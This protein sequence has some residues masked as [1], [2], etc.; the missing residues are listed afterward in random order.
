MRKSA[1]AG[2]DRRR[3]IGLLATSV[4]FLACGSRGSDA[5]RAPAAVS[6]GSPAQAPVDD[7]RTQL[8]GRA[9]PDG[10]LALTY[11]DGP[12][13][14]TLDLAEYLSRK[15]IAATFFVVGAWVPGLS[16]DPGKGEGV[17]ASGADFIPVLDDLRELGQRIANHTENHVLLWRVPDATVR[18]QLEA[19]QKRIDPY[20]DDELALFR[21]PGGAWNDA[22]ANAIATDAALSNL[23]GPVRWDVDRKD[24]E[25][26]L[27]CDGARSECEPAAP[28][29]AMRVKPAV[30]ARRYLDSIESAKHGIVLFHTRLGHVGSRYSVD[31]AEAIVPELEARGYVFAAPVLRFSSPDVRFPSAPEDMQSFDTE[32][33]R[34]I[35]LGDFDGDGRADVCAADGDGVVCARSMRDASAGHLPT[36]R[37]SGAFHVDIAASGGLWLA[38]IDGD[39][40]AD[41]CAR[42]HFRTTCAIATGTRFGKPSPRAFDVDGGAAIL[43]GDIDGDKKADIC[44]VFVDGVHCV[45]SR[46]KSRTANRWLA[47]RRMDSTTTAVLA[48]VDGD[49]LA[50]L[51]ERVDGDVECATSHGDMFM[52]LRRRSTDATDP[53]GKLVAMDLNGDGRVDLC[54]HDGSRVS[55]AFARASTLT[56]WSTWSDHVA[57]TH[58]MTSTLA[59]GDINGDG[60]SD[61]CAAT[62]DGIVCGVAP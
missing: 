13:A 48:D 43:F 61:I 19:N 51:C 27:S 59:S 26:S 50:D 47:D 46:D 25:G 21:V 14:H 58:T 24:W 15:R 9:F 54:A 5:N 57:G 29:G 4:L 30:M 8:D 56:G 28:G 3:A 35:A 20:I 41:L 22:D 2:L 37:F 33:V 52:A 62:T 45:A 7:F 38:D 18:A 17:F 32:N 39:G 16:S 40:R 10:V 36:T 1:F 23:V 44:G 31:L 49:G 53:A 12:D 60:R 55:C 42:D 6:T 34:S 11:D